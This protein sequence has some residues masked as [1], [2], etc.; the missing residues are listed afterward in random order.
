MTTEGRVGAFPIKMQQIDINSI[1]VG[2][3][4]IAALERHGRYLTVGPRSAGACRAPPATAAAAWSRPSPT[5]T[6]CWAARRGA[7]ARRRDQ[8]RRGAARRRPS[9]GWRRG[10]ASVSTRWRRASSR[11]AAVIAGRRHQGGV[12]HARH[13]PARLRAACLRRRGAA[14]CRGHRRG[15]RHAHGGG[16]AAARQFLGVRAAD[17]RRAARLRAH[18]ASRRPRDVESAMCNA[19]LAGAVRQRPGRA[20]RGRLRARAAPASPPASTCATP[21]SRSSCPCRWR[22]RSRSIARDR[23]APSARSTRHATERRPAAPIE[24]VSYRLAAWGLSDKPR[25]AG[26]RRG[27]GGRSAAAG[28]AR[29][30]VVF[31]GAERRCR[32]SGA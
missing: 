24:I 25:A 13:R 12:G 21:A 23:G 3:G 26:D 28:S 20:G 15:A 31:G 18:R 5:P 27:R 9:P 29:A 17:R 1:G 22:S 10:S 8:A 19:M 30:R 4:S 16:A 2:G 11:I 14:A 6:W 7:A 32:Y